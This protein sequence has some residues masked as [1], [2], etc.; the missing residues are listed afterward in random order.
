MSYESIL[1]STNPEPHRDMLILGPYEYPMIPRQPFW[2]FSSFSNRRY[3]LPNPHF[4]I[5]R[6]KAVALC[7]S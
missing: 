2:P 3:H 7:G 4:L 1:R 5:G 6:L